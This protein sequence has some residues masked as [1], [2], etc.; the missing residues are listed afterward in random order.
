VC[1][2]GYAFAQTN[3]CRAYFELSDFD[4][5]AQVGRVFDEAVIAVASPPQQ[6]EASIFVDSLAKGAGTPRRRPHIAPFVF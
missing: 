6:K 1:G 3:E 5:A 2:A 4:D